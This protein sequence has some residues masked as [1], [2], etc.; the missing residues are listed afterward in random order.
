MGAKNRIL[1]LL[2]FKY[3]KKKQWKNKESQ[4]KRGTEN[5]SITEA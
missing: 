3:K 2:T 4:R 1:C 5:R